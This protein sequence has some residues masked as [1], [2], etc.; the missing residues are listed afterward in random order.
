MRSAS[1]VIVSGVPSPQIA[2]EMSKRLHYRGLSY[3]K[4]AR[5]CNCRFIL[6]ENK[7]RN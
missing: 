3:G 6:I 5:R 1:S 2:I 4:A 7:R